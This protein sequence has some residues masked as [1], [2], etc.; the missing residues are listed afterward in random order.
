MTFKK[1]YKLVVLAIDGGGV[2]G[3]VP[4]M[5]LAEIEKRTGRQ[6]HELFDLIAGTCV[7]L[8]FPNWISIKSCT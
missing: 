6:I 7:S 3:I 8:H 1:D 2:K 4:A 5:I